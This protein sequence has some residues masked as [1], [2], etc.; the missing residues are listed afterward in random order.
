MKRPF[1]M[2]VGTAAAFALL[3]GSEARAEQLDIVNCNP[4]EIAT[5]TSAWGFINGQLRTNQASRNTFVNCIERAQLVETGSC[6]VQ[7]NRSSIY[8]PIVETDYNWRF[9]CADLPDPPNGMKNADAHVKIEGA[10]M[11]LDVGF[12][13]KNA[14]NTLE[15]A[16]V[17]GHELMHNRGFT[18]GDFTDLLYPLTV[19]EQVR[20]CIQNTIFGGAPND[21]PYEDYWD[22]RNC[23]QQPR[24]PFSDSRGTYNPRELCTTT[25]PTICLPAW[26]DAA[27]RTAIEPGD[28]Y[29]DAFMCAVNGEGDGGI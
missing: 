2:V 26:E 3:S 18:H 13:A 19:P 16:G 21:P 9:E 29:K 7:F 24:H 11:R 8:L 28:R 20:A 6:N 5:I 15:V 22:R 4:S 17:I 12:L 14:E 23:C 25:Y 1:E 10:K 27:T